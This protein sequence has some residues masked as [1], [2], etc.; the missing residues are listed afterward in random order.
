MNKLDDLPALCKDLILKHLKDE[1]IGT[2]WYTTLTKKDRTLHVD[3]DALR[4]NYERTMEEIDRLNHG[5]CGMPMMRRIILYCTSYTAT[6][7][8]I[9]VYDCNLYDWSVPQIEPSKIV[10]FYHGDWFN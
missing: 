6:F 8:K 10:M 4:S 3:A 1:A 5:V 9:P 7:R 2:L